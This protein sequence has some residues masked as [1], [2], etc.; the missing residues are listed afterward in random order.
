[1]MTDS[2]FKLI[3][4]VQPDNSRVALSTLYKALEFHSYTDYELTIIDVEE[5]PR[6]ARNA[7]I[8]KTPT[9]VA[10]LGGGTLNRVDDFS[11][12]NLIRLMLGFKNSRW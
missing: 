6:F 4:Y 5:H 3:L 1:M 2:R 11:D 9:V 8:Q 12:I 10:D 7:S